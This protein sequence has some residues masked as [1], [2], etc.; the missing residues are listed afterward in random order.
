MQDTKN[1]THDLMRGQ[2]RIEL[3][4][5]A[6]AKAREP[7]VHG[8]QASWRLLGSW[9]FAL[10]DFKCTRDHGEMGIK[11]GEGDSL[12]YGTRRRQESSG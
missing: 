12:V 9:R 8:G 1:S 3:L 5:G 6:F 4:E 2:G 11:R 10:L 7:N